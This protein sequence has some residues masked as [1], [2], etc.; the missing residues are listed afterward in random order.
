MADEVAVNANGGDATSNPDKLIKVTCHG[1]KRVFD[2]K[3]KILKMFQ[4]VKTMLETLGDEDDGTPL[5]L[6]NGTYYE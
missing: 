4:F 6:T 2:V 1:G 5:P 3:L